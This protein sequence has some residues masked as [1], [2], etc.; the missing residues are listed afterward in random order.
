MEPIRQRIAVP[1]E[2]EVH[3][4]ADLFRAGNPLLASVVDRA[5]RMLCVIDSGVADANPSLARR[6]EEYCRAEELKLATPPVVVPGGE[7][8]KNTRQY[9]D[10]LHAA[11]HEFG[12]CRHSSLVAVGGGAVL[13]M[14]GYGA[15]T[16]HRGVRLVRVPTT[17]L[18]QNDSGVGVK[19]GINAFGR[20]NFLGVF[21]P[22]FAVINDF[23][24]LTTLADRDWRAGTAEAVKVALIKDAAFFDFLEKEAAALAARDMRPMRSLIEHCAKMH[25]RHIQSSGDPFET[26]SSRP[27]DFGHWSAHKLEQLSQFKIRH[28]EAVAIG[29]ALDVVYSKKVGLLGEEAAERILKLLEQL[30]FKLFADELLAA[31][32]SSQFAVLFGLEEFREHLGGELTITLLSEIGRGVEVHEMELPQVI[33]AIHELRDRAR[34]KTKTADTQFLRK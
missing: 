18:S 21:A 5:Y 16:A 6:V 33:A 2:Y 27:L 20:K 32:S 10:Q 4:T 12:I 19:N 13:D 8:V 17:V 28:G 30:G 15:A 29:I 26:G 22:P 1:F 23:E 25:V 3:F 34:S 24:F 9:V 14:A 31:D 7:R 11:I